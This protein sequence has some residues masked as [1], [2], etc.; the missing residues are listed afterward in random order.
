MT[1]ITKNKIEDAEKPWTDQ[2]GKVITISDCISACWL[3][4]SVLLKE[5][6]FNERVKENEHSKYE[7]ERAR[8]IMNQLRINY[9]R[10]LAAMAQKPKLLIPK[11]GLQN[12]V[13]RIK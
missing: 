7:Y 4:G 6:E 12:I 10:A 3:A 8:I 1:A 2:A 5:L 13:R 11:A 9:E